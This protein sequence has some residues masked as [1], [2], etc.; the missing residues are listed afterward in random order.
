MIPSS[1]S[2]SNMQSSYMIAVN[3]LVY[4]RELILIEAVT[5]LNFYRRLSQQKDKNISALWGQLGCYIMMDQYDKAY[6]TFVKLKD[7]VD[8]MVKE[9]H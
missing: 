4:Y 8:S 3:M 7:N 2:Y 5:L 6:E 1:H 9:I